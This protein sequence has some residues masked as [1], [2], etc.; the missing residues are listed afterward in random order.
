[1]SFEKV[2]RDFQDARKGGLVGTAIPSGLAFTVPPIRVRFTATASI[3]QDTDDPDTSS[4]FTQNTMYEDF[5]RP[6]VVETIKTMFSASGVSFDGIEIDNEDVA[7]KEV[8]VRGEAFAASSVAI[9]D[10]EE[11]VEW[12]H[13][14]RL[15]FAHIYS[16]VEDDYDLADGSREAV[17]RH[18]IV[19]QQLEAPPASPPLFARGTGV[20]FLGESISR[21]ANSLDVKGGGADLFTYAWVRRYLKVSPTSTAVPLRP[22]PLGT[23]GGGGGETSGAVSPVAT[24]GVVASFRS[25]LEDSGARV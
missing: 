25:P 12:E 8:T 22:Q 18:S 7:T 9:I 17:L 15:Q 3:S 13:N 2:P 24:G 14:A 5:I 10:V 20:V 6:W 16:G 23:P 1:M 21:K 11:R 19:I 4:P